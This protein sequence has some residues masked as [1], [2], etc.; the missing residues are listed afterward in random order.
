MKI[1]RSQDPILFFSKS[2]KGKIIQA[3]RDAE[4]QTSGEIRLHLE[5]KAKEDILA[6]AQQEF[7]RI[8]MT[9]TKYRNGVLIFIGI[10]SR[11]FAIL[12]DEGIDRKVPAG[13]WNSV[14]EETAKAFRE[15]RFADGLTG[16]IMKIGEKL[17]EYFP[18]HREDVNELPDEIS[19]SA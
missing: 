10:R 3:I 2:E 8:G 4:M 13:F 12:G 15:D 5:R 19:Y 18:Y 9:R 14:V 11:R 6:H 1:E 17:R 16:A 7:E